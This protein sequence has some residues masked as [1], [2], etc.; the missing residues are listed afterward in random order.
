MLMCHLTVLE[1][2]DLLTIMAVEAL[3]HIVTE[4]IYLT[5]LFCIFMLAV[6]DGL[7]EAD[8]MAVDQEGLIKAIMEVEVEHQV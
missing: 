6:A 1:I 3:L 5:A 8:T 7:K 4:A 2:V